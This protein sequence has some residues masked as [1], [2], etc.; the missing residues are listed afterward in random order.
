[1][2]RL[3]RLR[4]AVWAIA[5]LVLALAPLLPAPAVAA[6]AEAV[7]SIGVEEIETGQR[8]YGLSVFSGD[9]VER[10]EVEVLGVMRD[11]QPDTDFILARLSGQNLEETGVIAGMSGSP[12]YIDERLAG[13]VAFSWPFSQGAVAGITPIGD[14]RDLLNPEPTARSGSAVSTAKVAP[15]DLLRAPVGA[16]RL[17]AALEALSPA[18]PGRAVTGIQWSAAGFGPRTTE[19]LRAN[20]AGFALSGSAADDLDAPLEPG[21]AVAAVLVDGDLKMAATGTVTDRIGDEIL[22][23]G[24]PFLGLGEMS[25]PMAQAEVL[26]VLSSQLVSFKISGQGPVVGSFTLDRQAG[27]R[28]RL[29]ETAP[30]VPVTIEVG[31][32]R[33][34]RF[35]L[36][37]AEVP[38]LMPVLTAVSTLGALDSV[39]QSA[40]EQG[41]DLRAVFR[42]GGHDPLQIDQ[43]FDGD[44][45]SFE[46]AVYLMSIVDYLVRN[47]FEEVELEA[48]EIELTQHPAPRTARLVGAHAGHTV[49]RPGDRVPLNLELVADRGAPF[50]HSLEVRI[51]EGLPAGRYSLLVGDG[52]TMDAVRLQVEQSSPVTLDQALDLL[53]SFHSRRDLVVLGVFAGKGLAVAGDL[54]PQL[55]GSFRSIWGAAASGSAVPL[56]LAVAQQEAEALDLPLEGGVRIDLEVR[57]R[58]PLSASGIEG[59]DGLD[60]GAEDDGAADGAALEDGDRGAAASPGPNDAENES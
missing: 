10:F 58:R 9:R 39:T 6:E 18:L 13:A 3:A 32:I 7:A 11:V 53:R 8:G 4:R 29:G 28:G 47:R 17:T 48:I 57:R 40:G 50:R 5:P 33:E 46:A 27:I 35:E 22:A 20:L 21:R 2:N 51:P 56:E 45:G 26:T 15:I 19:L 25:V 31:G 30:T 37:L 60:E 16:E 43:S 34:Q 24:H 14:M 36:R 44:G 55:P 59:E 52:P 1:M 23:F 38:S 42:L 49:V 12:V 41:L 54:L